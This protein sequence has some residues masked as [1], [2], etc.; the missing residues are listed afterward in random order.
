MEIIWNNLIELLSLQS[1]K[2]VQAINP[3]ATEEELRDL[4]L[5]LDVRLPEDF[6][7]FYKVHNGQETNSPGI[8]PPGILLSIEEILHQHSIWKELTN[9]GTFYKILS[10]P[11]NGI[12]NDWYNLKW[13]PIT[14]DGTGDHICID[15]DPD[16][17]GRIGQ[18]IA[19]EHDNP[20]RIIVAPSF[21]EWINLL[22]RDLQVGKY[23][24]DEECG[25]FEEVDNTFANKT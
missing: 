12:K 17:G 24:F 9:S 3:P 2:L 25:S 8:I 20:V 10:D 15:M 16:K 5:K 19:F 13:I 22:I 14:H 21:A 4:E 7:S 23:K 18:I 11:E 6:K 1:E